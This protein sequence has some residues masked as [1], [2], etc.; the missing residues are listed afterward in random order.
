MLVLVCDHTYDQAHKFVL[1]HLYVAYVSIVHL[2]Y[3]L[4]RIGCLAYDMPFH[5]GF[6]SL[7]VKFCQ[8]DL[9]I[10]EDTTAS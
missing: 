3:I 4:M 7:S 1:V 8:L 2:R 9:I 10:L 6:L 5:D